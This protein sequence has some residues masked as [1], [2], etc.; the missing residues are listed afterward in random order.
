[1]SEQTKK[2]IPPVTIGQLLNQYF[3]C[4]N[5]EAEADRLAR[6]WLAVL[7]NLDHTEGEHLTTAAI[8]VISNHLLAFSHMSQHAKLSIAD[9]S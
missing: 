2:S 9:A 8:Q 5:P 7:S 3:H 1:M 4:E 6:C